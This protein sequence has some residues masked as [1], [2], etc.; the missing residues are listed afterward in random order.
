MILDQLKVGE[1]EVFCYILGCGESNTGVVIDPGG[2]VDRILARIEKLGLDVRWIINTHCHP[3]HTCGNGGLQEAT[4][5]GI[6]LHAD[7]VALL[8]DPEAAA[9][10]ARMGLPPSPPADLVVT[11]GD[12]LRAGRLEIEVL[13]TPGHTPGSICLLCRDNLFTGDALFVGSAGRVDLPGGDFNVLITALAHKIAPLPDAT[14][15]RPG[16]DYGDTPVSTVGREK[17]ENPFLGGEW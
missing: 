13:H 9:C 5:A 1:M 17:R 6:V 4:G 7:D 15:I 8:T 10:F 14:I 3:D 12:I 2:D 11:D 16:H